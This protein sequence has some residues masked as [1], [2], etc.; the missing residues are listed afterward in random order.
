M[1]DIIYGKYLYWIMFFVNTSNFYFWTMCY[2]ILMT[3]YI[4]MDDNI[5]TKKNDELLYLNIYM[6]WN[7]KRMQHGL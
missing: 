6:N 1:I 2:R 5:L 4:S 7:Y 3:Q